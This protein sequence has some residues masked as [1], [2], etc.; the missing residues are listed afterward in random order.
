MINKIRNT[1]SKF[2]VAYGVFLTMYCLLDLDS[3]GFPKLM[4][5]AVIMALVIVL[6]IELQDWLKRRRKDSKDL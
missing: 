6:T 4:L 5:K 3:A 2:F 1:V